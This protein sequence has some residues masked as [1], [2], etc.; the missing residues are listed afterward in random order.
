MRVR[1]RAR[2]DVRVRVRVGVGGQG[3]GSGSG[4]VHL[5]VAL[6]A[7]LDEGRGL[8]GLLALA[9]DVEDVLLA[10]GHARDVVLV[11]VRVRVRVRGRVR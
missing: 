6:L 9:R 11:R 10:L 3:Q 7:A 4:C 1:V 5:E 2:V 8:D